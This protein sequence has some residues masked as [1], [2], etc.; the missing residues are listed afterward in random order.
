MVRMRDLIVS[1]D[2]QDAGWGRW[3]A[4]RKIVKQGKKGKQKQ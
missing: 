3:E 2:L 1:E 4:R